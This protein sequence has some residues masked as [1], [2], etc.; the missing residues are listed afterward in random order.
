MNSQIENKLNKIIK[1]KHG[2][3]ASINTDFSSRRPNAKGF[4]IPDIHDGTHREEGA[5]E[6]AQVTHVEVAVEA[7]QQKATIVTSVIQTP[8]K[9]TI[10]L[11]FVPIK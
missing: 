11:F 1:R 3:A 9:T 7:P 2:H 6:E 10:V 5:E 8:T 4:I